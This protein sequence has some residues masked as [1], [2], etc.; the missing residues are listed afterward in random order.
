MT[1]ELIFIHQLS[2]QNTSSSMSIGCVCEGGGAGWWM[3][4]C[5]DG[6]GGWMEGGGRGPHVACRLQE[7]VISPCRF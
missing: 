7:M 5:V 4:V 2:L 3:G 1:H 6:G